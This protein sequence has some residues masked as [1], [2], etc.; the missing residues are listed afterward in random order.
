MAGTLDWHAVLSQAWGTGRAAASEDS[1]SCMAVTLTGSHLHGAWMTI[2]H[3]MASSGCRL[4]DECINKCDVRGLVNMCRER[5]A[6]CLAA[7]PTR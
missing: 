5:T 4:L 7:I 1:N 2:K 3:V 6:S